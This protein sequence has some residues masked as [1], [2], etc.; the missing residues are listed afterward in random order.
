M[1]RVSV[2]LRSICGTIVLGVA[3]I[4]APV[5]ICS[6]FTHIGDNGIVAALD[7]ACS[8]WELSQTYSYCLMGLNSVLYLLFTGSKKVCS[9]R[10][11][12]SRARRVSA[13]ALSSLMGLWV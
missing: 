2:S 7:G 3:N 10:K 4:Y 6:Y 13:D 9:S 12:F 8:C 5:P 1:C 11:N